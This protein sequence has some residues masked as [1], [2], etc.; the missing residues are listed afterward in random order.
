MKLISWNKR[1]QAS[2][3]FHVARATAVSYFEAK[4]G[5]GG[6]FHIYRA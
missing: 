5:I 3:E 1:K 6:S 2:L 4:I